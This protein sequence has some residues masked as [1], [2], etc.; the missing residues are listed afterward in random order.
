MVV[1]GESS[2][3]LFWTF[4]IVSLPKVFEAFDYTFYFD[5]TRSEI[6]YVLQKH[7]GGWG[8]N[9]LVITNMHSLGLGDY[10]LTT[11][12]SRREKFYTIGLGK[13][14]AAMWL[15]LAVILFLFAAFV[16]YD[17]LEFLK[18][19]ND[20]LMTIVYIFG[21]FWQPPE[22]DSLDWEKYFLKIKWWLIL[23]ESNGLYMYHLFM[24]PFYF[25]FVDHF[26]HWNITNDKNL[27]RDIF[28]LDV[29]LDTVMVYYW[30]P[31]LGLKKHFRIEEAFHVFPERKK[32]GFFKAKFSFWISII[33]VSFV[34]LSGLNWKK[35]VRKI[36]SVSENDLMKL[37]LPRFIVL[38]TYF[39]LL[40]MNFF[41]A[42]L[43][44]LC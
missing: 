43:N 10:W 8:A 7:P 3:Y 21:R 35:C 9:T 42:S 41:W 1:G 31:I 36:I 28:V 14:K 13:M 25:N 40:K 6:L 34:E 11:K 29:L 15:V 22:T 16:P 39:H 24:S 2:F 5:F 38:P 4:I 30:K 26:L 33:I 32:S 37:C 17:K 20:P 23:A 18:P 12:Y 27:L 44:S 19:Y